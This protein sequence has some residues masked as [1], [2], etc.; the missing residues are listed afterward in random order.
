MGTTTERGCDTIQISCAASHIQAFQFHLSKRE[1]GPGYKKA[2]DCLEHQCKLPLLEKLLRGE[3]V[4]MFGEEEEP[5]R[6]LTRDTGDTEFNPE[7]EK[8]DDPME[9]TSNWST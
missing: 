1:L 7:T 9:D 2:L 8:K 3:A 4:P 6:S 5:T